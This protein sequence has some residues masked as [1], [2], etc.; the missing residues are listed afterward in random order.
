LFDGITDASAT[1]LMRCTTC[2]ENIAAFTVASSGK[3]SD[4][5]GKALGH[6]Q[7][8][9]LVSRTEILPA[10][11]A[12]RDNVIEVNPEESN[13]G[14]TCDVIP[15]GI[16]DPHYI[17]VSGVQATG[18]L[19]SSAKPT[20][21]FVDN[22]HDGLADSVRLYFSDLVVGKRAASALE[23]NQTVI[24]TVKIAGS[25]SCGDKVSQFAGQMRVQLQRETGS[26]PNVGQRAN[27]ALKRS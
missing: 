10:I 1:H 9:T 7:R 23:N 12:M 5:V 15:F 24:D 3:Y 13:V 27:V 25:L 16:V 20:A 6:K 19:I 26:L 8:D 17:D 18:A 21:E 22:D 4:V 14:F 2:R 11:I